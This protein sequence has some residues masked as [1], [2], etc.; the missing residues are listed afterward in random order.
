MM[1]AANSVSDWAAALT[2]TQTFATGINGTTTTI[3]GNGGLNV[4]D[5]TTGDLHNVP[6]TLTGTANDYFVFNLFDGA[7]DTNKAMVLNGVDPNHI[8]FNLLGTG[9]VFQ[10]SGGDVL[11]GTYLA[12]N[13]A[14]FQ[15]S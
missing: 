5:A 14:S 9:T 3:T 4:I 15:F 7:V 10:T 6:L 11:F 13:G 2:A 1:Q 8:L 12:V